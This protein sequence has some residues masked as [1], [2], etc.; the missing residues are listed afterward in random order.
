ME[1]NARPNLNGM[2]G[3]LFL[4]QKTSNWRKKDASRGAINITNTLT[5]KRLF[6]FHY[7]LFAN[8]GYLCTSYLF[9]KCDGYTGEK[10]L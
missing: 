2:D 10:C 9:Y 3:H 5:R 6:A 7:Q 8:N 4:Y 1:L